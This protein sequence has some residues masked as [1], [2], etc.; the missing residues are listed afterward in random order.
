MPQVSYNYVRVSRNHEIV[1]SVKP[2]MMTTSED[3]RS[4]PPQMYVFI[5][6]NIDRQ[7]NT[8]KGTSIPN[9]LKSLL[10]WK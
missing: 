6:P 4:Y 10:F 7:T 2:I 5:K 8:Q 1:V 3:L 9:N